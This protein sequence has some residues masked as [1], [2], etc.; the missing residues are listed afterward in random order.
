MLRPRIQGALKRADLVAKLL[1]LGLQA[2]DLFPNR[3][4]QKTTIVRRDGRKGQKQGLGTHDS[5]SPAAF[6]N[7]VMNSAACSFVSFVVIWVP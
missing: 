7:L 5:S 1:D 3:Q 4:T 2:I 6:F